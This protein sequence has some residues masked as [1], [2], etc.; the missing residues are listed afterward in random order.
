MMPPIPAPIAVLYFPTAPVVAFAPAPRL[1][2]PAVGTD[3]PVTAPS[4]VEF[5][6]RA[7]AP[8]PIAVAPIAPA[9]APPAA[10]APGPAATSNVPVA[11]APAPLCGS[12]PVALP[13]K[14]NCARAEQGQSAS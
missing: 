12:P 4:E 2:T 5:A 9:A 14:T 3:A 11:V 10:W 13:P 1:V 6:P 8:F 7:N